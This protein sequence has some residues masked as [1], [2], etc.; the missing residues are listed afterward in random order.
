MEF[1]D[2]HTCL[3]EVVLKLRNKLAVTCNK[4]RK[5]QLLPVKHFRAL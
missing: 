1:I 3:L 4:M 5:T 2:L